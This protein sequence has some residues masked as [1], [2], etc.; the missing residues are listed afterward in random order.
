MSASNNRAVAVLESL[1]SRRLLSAELL[2]TGELVLIGT[3]GA[4]V[5]IVGEGPGVGQVE[6]FGVDG[7]ADGEV[8]QGVNALTIRLGA[9]NDSAEITG[10]PTDTQ[11]DLLIASIEGSRGDDQIIGG[12]ANDSI[13]GGGGNDDLSGGAG[14]DV[15]KGNNGDDVMRGDDGNDRLVGGDGND[16]LF[17]GDGVDRLLG[18]THTDQLFGEDG[19]DRL[20]GGS[21]NDLLEGG[22]GNDELFGKNGRDNLFGG[23]G[24]DFLKGNAAKDFLHGGDGNDVL[25][26]GA[27]ADILFGGLGNDSVTGN[28]GR[29]NFRVKS[30]ERNDF[31]EDD[32]FFS[33]DAGNGEDFA[34]I[35]DDIWDELNRLDDLDLLN[36]RIWRGVDGTQELLAECG[37]HLEA[38]NDEFVSLPG[39][40]QESI[41]NQLDPLD[42]AFDAVIGDDLQGLTAQAVL[43]FYDGFR[44]VDAPDGLKNLLNAYLSCID[45]NGT[46]LNRSMAG[47]RELG[48]LGLLN[49]TFDEAL[50]DDLLL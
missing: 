15:I 36:N 28:G 33:E 29:D 1:E 41:G 8:F 49:Q 32:A 25:Q 39:D 23:A 27:G 4:D 38:V 46:A 35:G 47:F 17:G 18:N 37:G 31:G 40:V 16:Q 9:G 21:G 5:I 34:V 42:A 6:V 48:S 14:N 26:G 30:F 45:S 44:E 7:V 10:S 19:A 22:N 43:D 12:P 50:F 11:G 3:D 20:V 2:G 24:D 13:K